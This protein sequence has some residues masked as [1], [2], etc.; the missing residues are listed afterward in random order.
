MGRKLANL[1]LQFNAN[2]DVASKAA[3]IEEARRI[4]RTPVP[5]G[6]MPCGSDLCVADDDRKTCAGCPHEVFEDRESVC[7]RLF[8]EPRDI[9][10]E[11][12][13][14]IVY[15]N[16]QCGGWFRTF[17]KGVEIG[18]IVEGSDAE[19]SRRLEYPFTAGQYE[20]AWSEIESLADAAWH[21]A[22]DLKG[23]RE[24]TVEVR[25]EYSTEYTVRAEDADEAI[26]KA[27]RMAESDNTLTNP[28]H[29]AERTSEIIE[30]REIEQER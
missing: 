28:E 13:S 24:F 26:E 20:A 2:G 27:E 25:E 22:N 14:R 9:E 21:E 8:G 16:T 15:K 19:F 11:R 3:M 10:D 29:F 18:T 30:E 23:L 4:L 17:D 6:G 1:V 12:L 5:F 7:E